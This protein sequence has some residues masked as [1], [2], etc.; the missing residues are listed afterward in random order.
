MA[1][2]HALGYD[3][4]DIS[5]V[6]GNYSKPLWGDDQRTG[7]PKSKRCFELATHKESKY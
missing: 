1:A 5:D 7:Y 4:Y 2:F 6:F 3:N